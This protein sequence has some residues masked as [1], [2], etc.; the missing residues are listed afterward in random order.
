MAKRE[1]VLLQLDVPEIDLFAELKRLLR[2]G[3]PVVSRTAGEVLPAM[4]NVLARTYR[5]DELA[6][7]IEALNYVFKSIVD[8]LDT[9]SKVVSIL[10]GLTP[11][12]R[13]TTLTIRRQAAADEMSY[14]PD[15]FRKHIE[16]QLIEE[17]AHALY[18]DSLRY[19]DRT[20]YGGETRGVTE[21]SPKIEEQDLVEREELSARVWS[22]VYL[23][24]AEFIAVGRARKNSD[25]THDLRKTSEAA[26]MAI[27]QMTLLLHEYVEKYGER[28]LKSGTEYHSDSL[29]RLA[30]WHP[31]FTAEEAARLR[32]ELTKSG[33]RDPKV[34]REQLEQTAGGRAL[35]G[36]WEGWMREGWQVKPVAVH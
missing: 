19:R 3:L 35:A 23:M 15:H 14:D 24:R 27:G 7:R 18:Q 21:G 4:R 22:A 12:F 34:F 32:L 13:S 17:F 30:G 28:I 25:G 10:F 36:K 11:G 29:I 1:V 2:H 5:Y 31:P 26:L 9:H 33:T 8:G 6:S 20:L 16:K